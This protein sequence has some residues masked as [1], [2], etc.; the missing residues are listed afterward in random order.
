MSWIL[1]FSHIA[2][3]IIFLTNCFLYIFIILRLKARC[4][5][6]GPLL[7]CVAFHHHAG[8][9][10]R[11]VMLTRLPSLSYF[12]RAGVCRADQGAERLPGAAAGEGGGDLGAQGREEQHQGEDTVAA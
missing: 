10:Q 11:I 9:L 8:L 5:L 7:I 1:H 12:C 2:T 3:V 4:R 6:S